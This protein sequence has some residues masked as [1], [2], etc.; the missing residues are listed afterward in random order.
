VVSDTSVG[1]AASMQ[2][3]ENLLFMVPVHKNDTST[4]TMYYIEVA[5]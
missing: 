2:S 1:E 3:T 4:I 5:M